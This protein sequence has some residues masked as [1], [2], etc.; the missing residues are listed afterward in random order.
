VGRALKDDGRGEKCVFEER[1]VRAKDDLLSWIASCLAMTLA[2]EGERVQ[3]GERN[4]GA[5]DDLLSW[6]A[7]FL[8]MT[9]AERG[10]GECLLQTKA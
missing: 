9:L 3:K 5:K 6:I 1:N 4:V 2:E 8:A 7:S 10:E